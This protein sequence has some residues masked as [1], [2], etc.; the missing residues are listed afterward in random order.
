MAKLNS[1][2]IISV[3]DALIGRTTACGESNADERYTENL[4]TL[5][6]VID[7]CL[8]EVQLSAMNVNSYEWSVKHNAELARNSMVDWKNWLEEYLLEINND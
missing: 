7:W 8:C 5:I 6:D 1:N 2:E 4:K 3:L